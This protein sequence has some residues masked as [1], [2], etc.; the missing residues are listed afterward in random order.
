MFDMNRNIK[1]RL[2][3][4]TK[5][6]RT[7]INWIPIDVNGELY[8]TYSLDP[9]RVMKCDKTTGDCR[10]IYEQAGTQ[11]HPF[12]YSS[13]HLRGGTPWVL[14][15]YPY[16]IG[17]A[18][19]VIVTISPQDNFSVY[20][21]NLVVLCVDPWKIV[22]V[23]GNLD[24]NGKWLL[25]APVIRSQTI[26]LPF[27]YPSGLILR[28]PDVIDVSGHLND[29]NGHIVRMSGIKSIMDQV[30]AKDKLSDKKVSP[31]RAAQQYVLE[32]LKSKYKTWRFRGDH[33]TGTVEN[34]SVVAL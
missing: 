11:E 14:Y 28:N 29:A 16:Y 12:T 9:L 13:D 33:L 19:N 26:L 6:H 27:F 17:V 20:N 34:P 32:S 8:Y 3:L 18:H 23:S 1:R 31:V 5:L 24:F 25:S 10:F 4:N 30:I 22:Y 2:K 15:K 7:E 21:A